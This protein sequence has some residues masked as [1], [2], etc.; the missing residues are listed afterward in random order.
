MTIGMSSMLR[1]IGASIGPALAA[2]YMQTN[3]TV[4]NIKGVSE[5]LPSTYS[6]NLIF[7]TAVILSIVSIAISIAL[8][9]KTKALRVN[10]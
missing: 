7:L 6:F 5:S 9:R 3:Q 2:M 1:I 8:S 10:V 4:I